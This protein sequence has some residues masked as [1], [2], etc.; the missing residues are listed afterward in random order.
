MSTV[1]LIPPADL[2]VN[3]LGPVKAG[4][5]VAVPVEMA[6]AAP[7]PQREVQM[8]AL[9]EAIEAHD[10]AAAQAC[11]DLIVGTA[12]NPPLEMGHGLLARGWVPAG[13]TPTSPAEPPADT[14]PAEP[15]ADTTPPAD[16]PADTKPGRRTASQKEG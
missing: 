14:P 2:D 4:V 3:G 5:P 6:G 16:P 8:Q 13:A 1:M 12:E 15:P 11:R 7:D 10:H 9:R